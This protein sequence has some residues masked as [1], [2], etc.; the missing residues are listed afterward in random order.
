[1]KNR[2]TLFQTLDCDKMPV[3]FYTSTLYLNG[4]FFIFQHSNIPFFHDLI[5]ESSHCRIVE[6]SNY[7]IT[8]FTLKRYQPA[9]SGFPELSSLL[10]GLLKLSG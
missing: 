2:K 9:E 3:E 7:H 6:L 10:S 4:Y 5:F 1:M 8:N